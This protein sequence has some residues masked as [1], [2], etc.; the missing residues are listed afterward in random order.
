MIQPSYLKTGDQIALIAPSGVI[1]N[2]QVVDLSK[3]LFEGW[4]LEVRIGANVLN[5]G[6]HFSGTDQE[7]LSDFQWAMD[8]P[9]I[10][11][12]FCLRGGYGAIRIVDDID[13][14]KFAQSPKWLIGYSDITVL[15]AAF[16]Q[17]GY[18]SIHGML[19]VNLFQEASPVEITTT[20][21]RGILFGTIT[22]YSWKSKSSSNQLGEVSGKLIGGNLSLVYSL[23][24]SNLMSHCENKILFLEEVGEYKYQIDRMLMSLKRA[25]VFDQC[26]GLLIGDFSNIKKNNPYFGKT[27]PEIV[28]DVLSDVEIPI[29]FDFPAG[30]QP[31]NK[32][33]IFGQDICMKIGQLDCNISF[34]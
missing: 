27:I 33:L 12:I 31:I 4:G 24:G 16:Q 18:R 9:E 3:Q 28:V 34:K 29:A 19:G 25:G 8:T 13:F 10:K 32:A 30:H 1:K 2:P 17:K 26:S 11:A 5:D 22:E 14:T 6:N 21:L 23:L 15:H 20:S 7:R